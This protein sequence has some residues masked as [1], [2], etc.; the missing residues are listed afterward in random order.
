MPLP[1]DASLSALLRRADPAA[2]HASP[3][4]GADEVSGSDSAFS[5]AVHARIGASR[6]AASPFAAL[7]PGWFARQAL[8]FAAAL[9]VIASLAVGGG[10]AYAREQRA[11]SETFATAYVRGIDPWLMHADQTSGLASG[12]GHEHR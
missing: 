7:F 5:A 6:P 9:A 8:P 1:D 4:A 11:R 2:P 10:L 12:A 3:H